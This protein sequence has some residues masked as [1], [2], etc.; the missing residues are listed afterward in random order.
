[1]VHLV[2]RF[3]ENFFNKI[4]DY[5]VWCDWVKDFYGFGF[6]GFYLVAMFMRCYVVYMVNCHGNSTL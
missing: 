6:G 1:M 2:I 4:F 3:L 5:G